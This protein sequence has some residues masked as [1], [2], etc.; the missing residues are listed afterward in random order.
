MKKSS[1]FFSL[2]RKSNIEPL[3]SKRLGKG[4]F[5]A[6]TECPN[7]G[8]ESVFFD[9]QKGCYVCPDCGWESKKYY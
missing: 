9:S 6:N 7:C 2:K 5:T 8:M 3:Y 4:F 1:K